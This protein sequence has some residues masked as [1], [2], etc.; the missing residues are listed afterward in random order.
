MGLRDL[1]INF[2][3]SLMIYRLYI[4]YTNYSCSF[5]WCHRLL[6]V[7]PVIIIKKETASTAVFVDYWAVV[8]ICLF[9][10]VA[11][12]LVEVPFFKFVGTLSQ[13]F[14]PANLIDLLLL[15]S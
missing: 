11:N 7:T 9:I 1:N 8:K 12:S 10:F 3:E 14:G 2:F 4:N 6:V 13:S 15:Y 5:V